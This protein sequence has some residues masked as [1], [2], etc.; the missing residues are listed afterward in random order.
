MRALTEDEFEREAKGVYEQVF[1]STS[2]FE[3]PF[4][5]SIQARA[6]LFPIHYIMEKPFRRALMKAAK[7]LNEESFY[8]SVLERPPAEKQD[9][10][11]H[12]HIGFKEVDLYE[13]LGYPFVLENAIY[14]DRG[15]WGL[16]FSHEGHAVIGG[17]ENFL[18]SV[19]KALPDG[20]KHVEKFIAHWKG[21]QAR[22]GSDL[23]WVRKLLNHIYP[24]GIPEQLLSTR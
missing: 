11:Y 14:S 6:I 23:E 16:M 10:A 17:P 5:A 12:W 3:M 13:S 22:F 4:V 7:D 19:I 8:L 2:A 15:S 20:M 18:E 24:D 21:N 9:R 1:N